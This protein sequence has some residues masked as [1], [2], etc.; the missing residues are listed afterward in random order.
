MLMCVCQVSVP[1]ANQ[2][3]IAKHAYTAKVDSPLGKNAE[4]DL[5][6]FDKMT[7]MAPH[8]EQLYWWYVEMDN[9]RRGY[10][11]ASYVMVCIA[12]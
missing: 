3:L 4:I 12:V 5:C 1:S 11:P 9:G 6:Q 2:R 10:V 7:M 8:P